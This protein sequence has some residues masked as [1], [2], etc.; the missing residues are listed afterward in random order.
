MGSKGNSKK[1]GFLASVDV[2][3]KDEMIDGY[4]SLGKGYLEI[5]E[6]WET[7]SKEIEELVR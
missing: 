7:V 3:I 5:L 4:K 1:K 6:E 2:I